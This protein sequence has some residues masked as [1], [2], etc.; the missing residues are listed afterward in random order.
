MSNVVVRTPQDDAEKKREALLL[1]QISKE[2]ENPFQ[3]AA[4]DMMNAVRTVYTQY[5]YASGV[6]LCAT[7]FWGLFPSFARYRYM[8]IRRYR[9]S[10]LLRRRWMF[11][12]PHIPTWNRQYLQRI[13]VPMLATSHEL[14]RPFIPAATQDGTAGDEA[15]A[16]ATSVRVGEGAESGDGF[17]TPVLSSVPSPQNSFAKNYAT[18]VEQDVA[19]TVASINAAVFA[20]MGTPLRAGIVTSD[21]LR[22]LL[23]RGIKQAKS[24]VVKVESP[25]TNQSIPAGWEVWWAAADEA[26]RQR[27]WHFWGGALVCARV[28]Q[29]LLYM[30]D[31]SEEDLFEKGV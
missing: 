3:R 5:L 15:R 1:Q 11:A 21:Q 14:T 17:H 10:Q 27:Q 19:K 7:V 30:P 2:N 12:T 13:N 6:L 9:K 16:T 8:H 28:L 29:D 26:K 4:D 18:E 25:S 31:V 22:A 24:T 20:S 23:L